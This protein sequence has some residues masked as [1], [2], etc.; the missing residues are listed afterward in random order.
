MAKIIVN[1]AGKT[2]EHALDK[3]VVKLGREA[4]ECDIHVDSADLSRQHVKFTREGKSWFVEDLGSKNG[5]RLNGRKVTKIEL[6]DG[7]E[8]LVGTV[9]ITFLAH[10]EVTAPTAAP[11]ADLDLEISLDEE[12][13]IRFLGG[14]R[15][16]EKVAL[17]G[18]FTVGRAA[19]CSLA[20]NE[21]GVSSTHA[22]FVQVD[23]HWMLRDL[24]STNGT[25]VNGEK[26]ME[27]KLEPGDRVKI[28]VAEFVFGLGA[29]EGA[30]SLEA[31]TTAVP[32][33]AEADEQIFAISERN[34]ARKQRAALGLWLLL[35]LGLAAGG[36]V[37]LQQQKKAESKVEG[38][39]PVAGNLLAEAATFEPD[40]V[41]GDYLATESDALDYDESPKHKRSGLF[42]LEVTV[43]GAGRHVL[44]F[45]TPV[46]YVN[47][48]DRIVVGAFMR[49]AQVS[50]A[51]GP[52]LV[53]LDEESR[54][55]GMSRVNAPAGLAAFTEVRGVFKPPFGTT[56]AVAAIV[57]TE[58]DGKFQ[59]DDMFVLK[60]APDQERG[61]VAGPFEVV[62]DAE[63]ALAVTRDADEVVA[64]G[65]FVAVEGAQA[66][67]LAQSALPALWSA[68]ANVAKWGGRTL[69]GADASYVLSKTENGVRW[70]GA[71]T[72]KPE[73]VC[74]ALR[75]DP[76]DGLATVAAKGAARHAEPFS[77][78][79]VTALVVG[80][81]PRAMRLTAATP[82]TVK[83]MRQ[84]SGY[85]LLLPGTVEGGAIKF[86]FDIQLDFEKET[87][88]VNQLADLAN[89][90]EVVDKAYGK[91]I[92]LTTDIINR[93]PFRKDITDRATAR[94]EDLTKKGEVEV[95]K[96][97]KR[98]EE[99]LFFRTFDIAFDAFAREAGALVE[100][101]KGSEIS[102]RAARV[103][104]GV[105]A[106]NDQVR[107]EKN[108]ALAANHLLRGKDLL[109]GEPPRPALARGF[110]ESVI[111]LAP[112]SPEAAE[113]KAQLESVNKT[114]GEK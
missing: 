96:L 68:D 86:A 17:L 71:Y 53:W 105:T 10:A 38:V 100:V 91:A 92:Q 4:R 111:E 60:L 74:V 101:Y 37:F 108:A 20:L 42:G 33:M 40:V 77:R 64:G 52:A 23:G 15:K 7:D 102:D 13:H 35:M 65:G 98:A 45:T 112:E 41:Q 43:R 103:L 99:M 56:K 31:A 55:L 34:M 9:T 63:G 80:S 26:S 84:K 29:N 75:V 106:A 54:V 16:G 57:A 66:T 83:M 85:W 11:V 109:L 28:G 14:D 46:D 25:L 39:K 36:L 93:F 1:A 95:A 67:A 24:G 3:D 88:E 69:A 32:V 22:E 18:R 58:A 104:A 76:D 79:G 82:M 19:S 21:K 49:T 97:E 5:T 62:L 72:G 89:R 81:G 94:L 2:S 47:P 114:L 110:F 107:R 8:L 59:I 78:D 44:R 30:A 12:A 113:A 27:K 90:A 70:E 50:G 61:V 48:A 6:E 51:V 73:G 87:A